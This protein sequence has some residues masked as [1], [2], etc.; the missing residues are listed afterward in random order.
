MTSNVPDLSST[1]PCVPTL[2]GGCTTATTLRMLEWSAQVGGVVC[3][4][5]V[6]SADVGEWSAEVG[7]WSAE[8]VGVVCRGSG[9]GLQVG[10]VVWEWSRRGI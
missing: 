1:S 5:R 10:G 3:R 6:G 8:I 7:V 2:G 9:C 4:G